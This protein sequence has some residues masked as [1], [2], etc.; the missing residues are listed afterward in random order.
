MTPDGRKA[1]ATPSFNW[2]LVCAASEGLEATPGNG[3]R[4]GWMALGQVDGWG[5]LSLLWLEKRAPVRFFAML[6]FQQHGPASFL[7]L[8]G[9]VFQ[10]RHFVFNNFSGLFFKI[11]SFLSHTILVPKALSHVFSNLQLN[12]QSVQTAK[13]CGHLAPANISPAQERLPH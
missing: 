10:A 9:F 4:A 12:Q 2:S 7:G 13:F 1:T 6:Y 5:G 3:S 11:T 8:F